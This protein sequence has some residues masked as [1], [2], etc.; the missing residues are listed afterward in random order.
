VGLAGGGCAPVDLQVPRLQYLVYLVLAQRLLQ[1]PRDELLLL[2]RAELVLH[3]HHHYGGQQAVQATLD[4]LEGG[5]LCRGELTINQCCGSGSGTFL[6]P[7]SG[8]GRK[9]ASGS[10]MNNPDH[11]F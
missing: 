11:I 3:G 8:I 9:S 10:G 1:V 2:G 7:G 4:P 5:D 6:A